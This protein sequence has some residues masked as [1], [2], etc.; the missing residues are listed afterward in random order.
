MKGAPLSVC[1]AWIFFTRELRGAHIYSDNRATLSG[2]FA[3]WSAHQRGNRS[4][5]SSGGGGS[6]RHEGVWRNGAGG[7]GG[8]GGGGGR[9]DLLVSVHEL[10]ETSVVEGSAAAARRPPTSTSS[11]TTS[12]LFWLASRGVAA[13]GSARRP[14]NRSWPMSASAPLP[15]CT[16]LAQPREG[17]SRNVRDEGAGGDEAGKGSQDPTTQSECAE[18][19]TVCAAAVM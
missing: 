16:A 13:A 2:N 4:T 6:R 14:N 9:A 8:G 1:A 7:G 5:T 3:L 17:T 18:H 19:A 10:Y 15:R 12:R 11:H